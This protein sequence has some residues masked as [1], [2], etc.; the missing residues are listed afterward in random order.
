[1]GNENTAMTKLS[2]LM[3]LVVGRG[4]NKYINMTHVQGVIVA[5]EK[6]K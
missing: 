5:L 4:V 2:T 6:N 3:E 1:M